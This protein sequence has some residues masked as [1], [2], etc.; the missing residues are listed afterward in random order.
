MPE[1]VAQKSTLSSVLDQL[2]KLIERLS[3]IEER[4]DKVLGEVGGV[5]RQLK[6][7]PSVLIWGPKDKPKDKA[8]EESSTA[9]KSALG[10]S[11]G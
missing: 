7:D 10:R 5:T 11:P 8:K 9:R 2:P 1:I 4:A 6:E 3:A